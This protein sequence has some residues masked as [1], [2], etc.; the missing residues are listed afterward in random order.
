M[1][2]SPQEPLYFGIAETEAEREL[3][4]R[5]RQV[6]STRRESYLLVDGQASDPFDEVSCLFYLRAGEHIVATSRI[7]PQRAGWELDAIGLPPELSRRFDRQY[8]QYSRV[9]VGS[10]HRNQSLHVLLFHHAARWTL[11]NTEYRYYVSVC[12]R[13]LMRIYTHF[14]AQL[15]SEHPVTIPGRKSPYY[16][17]QGSIETVRDT[18]TLML[19]RIQQSMVSAPRLSHTPTDTSHTNLLGTP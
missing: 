15:A 18:S 2:V 17:V 16:L 7:T 13:P 14:G 5:F 4:Y 10:A 12:R 6:N 1:E 3:I 8:I 11:E 19:H 9:L